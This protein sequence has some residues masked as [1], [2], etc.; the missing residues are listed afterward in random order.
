MNQ[1]RRCI[2][3]VSKLKLCSEREEMTVEG[4]KGQLLSK[5]TEDLT[6][7]T[8]DI[9]IKGNVRVSTEGSKQAY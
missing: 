6:N 3:A 5:T 1:P 9:L 4:R 7:E 8:I 2:L